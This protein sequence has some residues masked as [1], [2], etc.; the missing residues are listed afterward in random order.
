MAPPRWTLCDF[1]PELDCK[2]SL[3]LCIIP[4]LRK[5]EL[6][7]TLTTILFRKQFASTCIPKKLPQDYLVQLL[8]RVAVELPR[9]D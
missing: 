5:K 4:I 3:P 2:I 9:I 6:A 1:G 8:A 7:K